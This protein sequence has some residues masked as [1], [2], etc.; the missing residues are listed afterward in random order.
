ML[1]RSILLLPCLPSAT[2]L[3]L[4]YATLQGG[5]KGVKEGWRD[6]GTRKEVRIGRREGWRE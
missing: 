4:G 5:M 3:T 6:G 2:D 1:Y